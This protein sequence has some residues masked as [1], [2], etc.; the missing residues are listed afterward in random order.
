M[1]DHPPYRV[2]VLG[3][4][5]GG[6][7]LVNDSAMSLPQNIRLPLIM[8]LHMGDALRLPWAYILDGRCWIHVKETDNAECR[9]S[10]GYPSPRVR[11]RCDVGFPTLHPQ[12]AAERS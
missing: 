11:S 7:D 2:V 9:F 3:A 4:S 8:V 12:A 6:M 10:D 5:A 1:M